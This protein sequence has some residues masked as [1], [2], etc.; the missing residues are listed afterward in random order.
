MDPAERLFLQES[1]KAIE[2][3]G[4]DPASLDGKPWGVFCGGSGDYTLLLKEQSGVSP[5][6][7][8]SSIPA[9]VSYTLG[10]AGPSVVVDAGCASSLLAVAQACDQLNMGNCEVAIAGGAVLHSTLNMISA[11]IESGLLGSGR[12]GAVL[13]RNGDGMMASEGVGAVVLKPLQRAQDDGDRIYGIIEGWGS[14]HSGK[15]NGMA[16]PSARAQSDLFRSVMQRHHIDAQSIELVEGNATGTLLGDRMEIEALSEAFRDFTDRSHFCI[17]GS[18]ENHIGHAFHSSGIAHLL[19]VLLAMHHHSIPATLNVKE[20]HPAMQGSPFFINC[21]NR[22][23]PAANGKPR[24]AA[25]NSFG[26]TGTNVQLIVADSPASVVGGQQTLDDTGEVLMVLSARTPKALQLR[27][28]QLATFIDG[29]TNLS[30]RQLSANLM[31]RS[32]LN[33]RCAFVVQGRAQLLE[34]LA[35][36]GEGRESRGLFMGHLKENHLAGESISASQPLD[37]SAQGYVLGGRLH[38]KELFPGVQQL[39]MTLPAYPFEE[40]RCWIDGGDGTEGAV[41]SPF[42]AT[43]LDPVRAVIEDLVR[44][45]TGYARDEI[46]PAA[47]LNRYGLDSLLTMRLLALVN[48]H[49]DCRLQLA[50][51]LERESIDGLVELVR[52]RPLLRSSNEGEQWGDASSHSLQAAGNAGDWLLKRMS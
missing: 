14:N 2:D 15:T 51:L 9:R 30:L 7:T 52:G 4:V 25:I 11:A 31:R 33:V 16:A 24:R 43:A 41:P 44:E 1:W 45:V 50:D 32:H 21:E 35:A 38:W 42:A 12:H 8:S 13:D 49:F 34:R 40:R 48:R 3:A 26:A 20:S 39:P 22:P 28:R 18:V 10:L 47:P 23:W 5:H 36:V 46:D 27:A 29:R 6:V 37:K 19:K 17:L